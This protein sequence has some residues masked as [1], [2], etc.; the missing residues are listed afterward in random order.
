[1]VF[2]SP[3]AALP[4]VREGKL[5]ALAVTSLKRAAAGARSADHG[6]SRASPAS[7]P[8]AWFAF[9]APAGTPE[10][11]IAKLQRE[12]RGSWRCPT[13]ARSSTSS[14]WAGRQHAGRVRRRHEVETPQW[15][16]LIRDAGVKAAE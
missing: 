4:L 13:C 8:T 6:R 12:W 16:K 1:M 2:S 9:L 15:A 10:P 5:R 14:A 11:I 3:T 7:T